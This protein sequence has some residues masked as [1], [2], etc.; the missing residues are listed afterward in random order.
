M[1]SFLIVIG[2]LFLAVALRTARTSLLKK[3]GAVVFLVA[4]FFIGYFACGEICVGLLA[5]SFW[6]FLPWVELLT[7]VRKLRL[8]MENRLLYGDCPNP[9]F[10]PNANES[11]A[12]IRDAKFNYAS[13]CTWEWCGM[14][15]HLRLF[16]HED[17]NSVVSLCLCEQSDVAFSFVSI[18]SLGEDGRIWR[19]TNYPFAATLKSPDHLK[20][21]YVSCRIVCFQKIWKLHCNFLAKHGV[22]KDQL[23][24]QNLDHLDEMIEAELDETIAFNIEKGIIEFSENN[25]FSYSKKGLFYLWAQF[26]KDM[27]RLC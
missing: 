5:V 6:F 8:P 25:S 1:H 12:A 24:N 3:L 20:W 11:E 4:T 17:C 2:L 26:I 14:R 9:A 18:S 22:T 16:L 23:M 19:T 7:K 13:D 21:N 27:V 15:Q 10:Y